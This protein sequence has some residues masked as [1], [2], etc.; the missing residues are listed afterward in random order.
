VT[1]GAGQPPPEGYLGTAARITSGPAPELVEAG[2]ALEIGDAPLLHRG[3][4]LADLAH[5]VELVGCGALRPDEAAP[6]CAA[7]LDLLDSPAEEFPYDPVYGDA[8][9]S[10]ERE[11]EKALGP[12]AGR[13]H[14]G[15]TRREAGRIAFRLALRGKLLSL[16]TDVAA[17]ARETSRAATEHAATLW[18]DTT[19]LQPAQPSTFGHYIGGFA[20]QAVRHLD[21][22][23]A[24]YRAADVSPAG[25]GGAGGTR[26]PLDRARL[27]G[28]LGFGAVGPH[29][30]DAMWSVDAMADA[31]NA[32]AQ[33]VA[34]IGQLAADLEIFASPAFGYVTLDASLCRA[35]VLM[36]QKR[37]P[38]AL[39]VL[40]GGAGTVI[41]RLTGLLATGLTPSARTDN[42]LYAYGEVAGA[43]DLAGRLVRLGT[44]VVAGLTPDTEALGEQAVSHFTA[45]ADL[46]EELTQRFRLD[47]RTAYRVVGRAVAMTLNDGGTELTVPVVRAAAEEITGAPVP[48]TDGMLSGVTDPVLAV[49]ARS[50]LGGA[51]PVRVREHARRVRRR[52]A[53]AGKW[54]SGRQDRIAAAESELIAAARALTEGAQ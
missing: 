28:L 1:R 48:I 19:Y 50:A 27:G 3:L 47:Y 7:L 21:R 42:W 39:P 17:F 36:P 14:L 15:R 31:V 44:A 11:L 49:S 38:Y 35:S 8:Y 46:A 54:N 23:E 9:N 51:S 33:A 10:R 26:L 24:A 41:G 30:R 34:T 40:R 2:Y 6:V 32:A 29:T 52:A 13:L 45:A 20:E 22:I 4:T 12:A 53:A 25:C 37:N 5:L 16:H 43:M 18:A